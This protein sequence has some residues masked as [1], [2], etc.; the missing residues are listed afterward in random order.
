MKKKKMN[1]TVTSTHKS[2]S[3][4]SRHLSVLVGLYNGAAWDR[5]CVFCVGGFC[6]LFAPNTQRSCLRLIT[7]VG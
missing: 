4:Q 5:L 6:V 1:H 3:S 2:E 7:Q